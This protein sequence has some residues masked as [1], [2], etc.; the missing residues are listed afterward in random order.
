MPGLQNQV[1]EYGKHD[2]DF[3]RVMETEEAKRR[4]WKETFREEMKKARDAVRNKDNMLVREETNANNLNDSFKNIEN[5][6]TFGASEIDPTTAMIPSNIPV[7]LQKRP[8]EYHLTCIACQKERAE[9]I[10]EPCHH[11][12]I[13]VKCMENGLC[14]KFCP[15]CRTLIED[16]VIA[17]YA[18]FVRPRIF[19]AYSFI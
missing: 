11:C 17:S 3:M 1:Y 4:R 2:E 16:R 13:C 15:S 18:R 5:V 8:D 6:C 19:S 10:F 9:I 12:V 7:T 14:P